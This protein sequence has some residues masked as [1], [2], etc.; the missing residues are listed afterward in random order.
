MTFVALTPEQRGP[1]LPLAAQFNKW[2]LSLV[3]TIADKTT[4]VEDVKVLA[5]LKS[6]FAAVTA[7]KP[8]VPLEHYAY[9]VSDCLDVIASD[10]ERFVTELAPEIAYV[11]KLGLTKDKWAALDNATRTK[12]CQHLNVLGDMS[13]EL[14]A[15]IDETRGVS[16]G[17]SLD[18]A[19]SG[20]IPPEVL[21]Q[22]MSML[23]PA[24]VA[25]V[26]QMPGGIEQ[27]VAQVMS[28]NPAL[29]ALAGGGGASSSTASAAASPLA[30]VGDL[31]GTLRS[32]LGDLPD[33]ATPEQKNDFYIGIAKWLGDQVNVPGSIVS[34]MYVVLDA[35]GATR[36]TQSPQVYQV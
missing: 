28:Q 27:L 25:Q 10:P 32:Q 29:A 24:L 16:A 30:G 18:G 4:V 36:L 15:Y 23:P 6:A 22:I 3:D 7:L 21:Q 20:G 13:S 33:D 8:T 35:H 12:I 11:Q 31:I 9:Q 1:I 17:G 14:L 19:A 5:A 34:N 26:S 2:L